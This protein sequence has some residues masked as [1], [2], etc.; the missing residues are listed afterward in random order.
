MPERDRS[1]SAAVVLTAAAFVS[2]NA[3]ACSSAAGAAADARWRHATQ[4]TIEIQSAGGEA[5]ELSLVTT[6]KPRGIEACF[7]A[8]D[9]DCD[10]LW[11]EGC[12]LATGVL[13]LV[14]A[15]DRADV[16]VNLEVW[17]PRGEPARV[18]YTTALGLSK[19]RDCPGLLD[20]CR[21]QNV[22][23][24]TVAGEELPR[25]HFRLRV[26]LQQAAST[27]SAVNVQ[28]GGH[29]GSTPTR[30]SCALSSHNPR[31]SAE[32]WIRDPDLR[33]AR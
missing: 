5:L 2:L 25:G 12:G 21:G 16:D 24:V 26:E 30:G 31:R 15:W 20:E 27:L 28:I 18:G 9:D 13:Q 14:V 33:A 6:C 10:G 17:D 3:A 8:I 32:L 4:P 29:I 1:L 22:E 19:D 11:D 7:N 23:V